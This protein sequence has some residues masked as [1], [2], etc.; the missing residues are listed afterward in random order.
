M[1]VQMFDGNLFWSIERLGN[2]LAARID[3]LESQYV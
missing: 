3:V 1:P 2:L